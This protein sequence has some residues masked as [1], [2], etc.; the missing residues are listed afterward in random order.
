MAMTDAAAETDAAGDQVNNHSG[1]DVHDVRGALI[2]QLAAYVVLVLAGV[3][4]VVTGWYQGL[5]ASGGLAAGAAPVIILALLA[6]IGV[7][8][9]W[10]FRS[11]RASLWISL[12]FGAVSMI[13]AVTPLAC[14]I[15]LT[16]AGPGN[17]GVGAGKLAGRPWTTWAVAAGVLLVLLVVVSFGRQMAR[18]D[19]SHLIRALSHSVT[20][21]TAAIAAAGWCFLPE[22]VCTAMHGSVA[23]WIAVAVVVVL[24]AAM[25]FASTYWVRDADPEPGARQPWAGIALLPVLFLGVAVAAAMM[26]ITP[27]VG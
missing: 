27:F 24:G 14:M 17:T 20:G 21:G 5:S 23:A 19:R 15:G 11:G 2:V 26:L 12:L 9:C 3:V 22:M 25:A 10:P 4:P 1:H 6:M 18:K 8:V 13:F 16:D 7:H